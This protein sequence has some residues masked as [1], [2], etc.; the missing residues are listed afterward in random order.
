MQCSENPR[1]VGR[2]SAAYCA[3][4]ERNRRNTLRFPPFGAGS[5][6]MGN[7]CSGLPAVAHLAVLIT[8]RDQ[9]RIQLGY[10]LL[11]LSS[12]WTQRFDVFF[13]L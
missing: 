4:E 6:G 1:L 12:P 10:A 11:A 13:S 9:Q 3:V 5:R 2:N 8:T 7:G